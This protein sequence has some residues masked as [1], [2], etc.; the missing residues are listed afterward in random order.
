[1][2]ALVCWGLHLVLSVLQWKSLKGKLPETRVLTVDG[3]EQELIDQL[4]AGQVWLI[5][6]TS[7]IYKA[8]VHKYGGHWLS[9]CWA[10][11]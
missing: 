5:S 4:V 10:L 9:V 3:S 2:S 8:L 1:M 6:R 7:Q 11:H